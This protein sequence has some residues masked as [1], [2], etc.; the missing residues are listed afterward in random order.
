MSVR[1]D[2]RHH[3]HT[4]YT[5]PTHAAVRTASSPARERIGPCMRSSTPT[6]APMTNDCARV[7]VP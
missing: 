6:S 3:S 4:V 7:S 5:A 1:S 2:M